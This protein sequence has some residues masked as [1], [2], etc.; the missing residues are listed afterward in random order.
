MCLNRKI[1][2]SI[3]HLTVVDKQGIRLNN[4]RNS[5]FRNPNIKNFLEGHAQ[6]PPLETHTCNART[7]TYDQHRSGVV[8]LGVYVSQ[9]SLFQY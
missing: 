3:R 7:N 5:H 6:P 9:F 8:K 1:T 2:L 4:A